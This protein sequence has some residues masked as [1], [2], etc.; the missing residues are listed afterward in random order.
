VSTILQLEAVSKSFVARR[1]VFGRPRERQMAVDSV[2]LRV[3]SGQTLALVGES[4][5]GKST[6][7]RL[8]LLLEVPDNGTVKFEGADVRSLRGRERL[9]F[10]RSVQAVFQDPYT[11]LNPRMTIKQSLLEP[12]LVHGI[13]NAASRTA[14]IHELLERVELRA[15]VLARQPQEMSGGQLQRVCIAR[16][17]TVQPKLI[18]CDEAVTALDVL[19]KA[20]VIRL[21]Q[22]IQADMGLAYLFISHDLAVVRHLAHVVAVMRRGRVVE[23]APVEQLFKSP[24]DEYTEALLAATPVPD[25]ERQRQ[26]REARRLV[27]SLV[28]EAAS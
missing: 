4:G 21:L 16:A 18:V 24:A 9:G 19:V 28:D 26:R 12:L 27:G 7:G 17:L 11:S 8:A 6:V 13:G 25:P 20:N 10:R 23:E 14:R 3:E 22:E 1:N 5:A 15:G 2:S